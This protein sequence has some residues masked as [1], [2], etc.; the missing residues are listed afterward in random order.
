MFGLMNKTPGRKAMLHRQE[1]GGMCGGTTTPL[2]SGLACGLVAGTH[3]ATALGWRT[4]EAI[5]TGDLVL[6]FDRGLQPVRGVVRGVNWDRAAPLPDSLCPLHVPAGALGNQEVMTLMPEQSVLLESDTADAVFGDPFV[7]VAGAGLV[8]FRGIERLR[9]D[10]V[11][12]VI[13]LQFDTDEIVFAN[14]G[15]LVFC[16]D[17]RI[18]C[19]D[20]LLSAEA[21]TPPAYRSLPADEAAMLINCIADEDAVAEITVPATRAPYAAAI[22]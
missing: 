10:G 9:P 5:A 18:L 15:A 8:G 11:H 17:A 21:D 20:T 19:V 6:T 13:Q 7:L 14:L 12:E 1:T 2:T 22:A 4:V 3:V 16:P